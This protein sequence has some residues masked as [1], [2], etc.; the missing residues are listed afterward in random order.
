MSQ[1]TSRNY[2]AQH[3]CPAEY[4]KDQSH[5]ISSG[6]IASSSISNDPHRDDKKALDLCGKLHTQYGQ[7]RELYGHLGP[8]RADEN[9]MG[10]FDY[11]DALGKVRREPVDYDYNALDPETLHR[12]AQI[13]GHAI[14]KYG[15]WQQYRA[16][17]LTGE[18]S[19]INH[20]YEHIGNYRARV[21]YDRF[22]GHHTWH[23]VAAMY[24]LMMELWYEENL[25][26][27]GK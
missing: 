23:L 18:K 11:K 14:D 15:S 10:W 4:C 7:C 25:P 6:P 21:P 1:E 12:L 8:H 16:A 13:A 19:P 26:N 27:E 2:C 3:L 9:S 5:G 24:N 20:V 22:G 17:R